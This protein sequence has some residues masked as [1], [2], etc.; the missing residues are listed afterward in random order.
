ML[1]RCRIADSSGE[2][3]NTLATAS[4]PLAAPAAAAPALVPV[5]QANDEAALAMAPD[6][7]GEHPTVDNLFVLFCI[8][9]LPARGR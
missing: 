3:H 6:A 5:E 4:E 8:R 1:T 2:L 9:P 7:E